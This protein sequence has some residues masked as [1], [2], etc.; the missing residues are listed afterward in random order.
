MGAISEQ[1][2][3]NIIDKRNNRTLEARRNTLHLSVELL[4]KINTSAEAGI[5]TWVENRDAGKLVMVSGCSDSRVLRLFP[6]DHT[7][8]YPTIAAAG[9]DHNEPSKI[10]HKGKIIAT[11]YPCGGAAAKASEDQLPEGRL[12]RYVQEKIKSPNVVQQAIIEAEEAS[13][14]S[15]EPVLA[16]V[17]DQENAAIIPIAYMEHG[18]QIITAKN[19]E[20]FNPAN[21]LALNDL[22]RLSPEQTG[23]F[24][25]YLMACAKHKADFLDQFPDFST[26]QKTQNPPVLVLDTAENPPLSVRFPPLKDFLKPEHPGLSN[27]GSAFRVAIEANTAGENFFNNFE[28]TLDQVEYPLDNFSGLRWTIIQTNS[29]DLSKE[30]ARRFGETEKGQRWLSKPDTQLIVIGS[31][32]GLI[33]DIEVQTQN[34]KS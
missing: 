13:K 18:K 17:V 6:G 29:L 28:T 12:K 15:K 24:K 14:H 10:P 5:K 34:R 20:A 26:F 33:D 19:V 4:K 1:N 32:N 9:H 22:P 30:L 3:H 11:H 23:N 25:E 7:I 2:S 8:M 27:P 31:T 16:V 21:L